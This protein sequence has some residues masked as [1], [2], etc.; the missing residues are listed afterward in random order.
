MSYAVYKQL[1]YSEGTEFHDKRVSSVYITKGFY[2]GLSD[3]K[4][5][6]S[7]KLGLMNYKNQI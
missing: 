3:L 7:L 5:D 1:L 6:Y 4:N 2:Q